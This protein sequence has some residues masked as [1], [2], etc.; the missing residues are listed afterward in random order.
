V[1]PQV[2]ACRTLEAAPLAVV[3]ADI[4]LQVVAR[5]AVAAVE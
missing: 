4:P 1:A 3:R 2:V 5:A